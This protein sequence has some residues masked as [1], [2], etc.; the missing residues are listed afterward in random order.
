MARA[1]RTGAAIMGAGRGVADA[2]ALLRPR[3]SPI[4]RLR[5][6]RGMYRKFWA[7]REPIGT[8]VLDAGRKLARENASG[9]A[10][11]SRRIQRMRM[12]APQARKAHRVR[13][14]GG[15]RGDGRE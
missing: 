9:R 12:A 3:R 10:T 11:R 2:R 5:P 1:A 15:A 13:R 7:Y 4:A 8:R 14:T 6:M